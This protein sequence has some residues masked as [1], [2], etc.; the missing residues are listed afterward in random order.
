MQASAEVI[1]GLLQ[2]DRQI[3]QN[4][5]YR[6]AKK[7]WLDAGRGFKHYLPISIV[8]NCLQC[9][10]FETISQHNCRY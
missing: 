3:C 8:L 9:K 2:L 5:R 1:G 4:G 7:Q 6:V 10:A